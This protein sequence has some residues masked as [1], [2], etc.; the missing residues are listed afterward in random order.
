MGLS[1]TQHTSLSHARDE[2][3]EHI[4]NPSLIGREVLTMIFC[5]FVRG[6]TGRNALY[7]TRSCC[8]MGVYQFSAPFQSWDQNPK[9]TLSFYCLCHGAQPTASRVTDTSNSDSSPTWERFRALI[10]SILAFP[11]AACCSVLFTK[12]YKG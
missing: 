10:I 1:L 8:S 6:S 9:S 2:L 3:M 7:T 11:K 5:S 12:W 4:L